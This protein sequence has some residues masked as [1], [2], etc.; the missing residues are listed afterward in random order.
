MDDMLV[1][2]DQAHHERLIAVMGLV[3]LVAGL[4]L[5][6]SERVVEGIDRPLA[7]LGLHLH[8]LARGDFKR[9]MPDQGPAELQALGR[10]VNEMTAD[11]ARLYAEERERR[12]I[13][14]GARYP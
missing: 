2:T 4:G 9:Q 11:L 14:R 10:A 5:W 8:R 13:G 1:G 6:I 3:A 12:A 7:A